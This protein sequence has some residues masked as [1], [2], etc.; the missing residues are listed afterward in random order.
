MLRLDEKLRDSIL[1]CM[2]TAIYPNTNYITVNQIINELA[3]LEPVKKKK[4]P[5][6]E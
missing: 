2:V 4:K 5:P 6:K 3:K 1:S